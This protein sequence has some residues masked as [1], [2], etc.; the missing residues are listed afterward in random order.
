MHASGSN[1]VEII[2]YLVDLGEDPHIVNHQGD[3]LLIK[4]CRSAN[5]D[6]IRLALSFKPDMDAMNQAGETALMIACRYHDDGSVAKLLI[7][8]GAD[9]CFKGPGGRTALDLATRF[10]S[11]SA[12]KSIR[13]AIKKMLDD[14]D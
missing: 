2:E 6:L 10:K 14:V 3:T 12:V 5:I 9:P 11:E 1:C 8:H 13:E 4:A 7:R